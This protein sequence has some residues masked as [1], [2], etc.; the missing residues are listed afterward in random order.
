M[1][2]AVFHKP[3]DIRYENIADAEIENSTD[4]LLR[5]TSTSL[6]G[7][8]LHIYNGFFPQLRPMVLG[9]EFMGVVE[10]VGND[11][12]KF[13]KGDRVIVP[14]TIACG[15]CFFCMHQVPTG[16]SKSNPQNYG[17]EGGIV[18]SKGAGLFG[19]TDLY[20]GYNGGQAEAVRVPYADFGPRKVPDS[21]TDEQALFLT[22][23]LPTGWAG[24]DK[25]QVKAG[26]TVVVFGCGPVGLMAQKAAWYKGAKR[27]IA[28]DVLPYRLN[29]AHEICKSE[30]IDSS[31]TDAVS[32][33][34]ELTK[35][36]GADVCI[37]AV[38][39]EART[40][41]FEKAANVIN[42]QAGSSKIVEQA[43]HAT[44]RGGRISLLG[45]YATNYDNFPIGGWID[46]G[47]Q[48]WGGLA[49][50]HNYI[51]E[52][53]MMVE[54]GK[55]KTEDIITHS[56]RLADITKAYTMFNKKEDSCIKVILK[57]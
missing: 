37:D 55:L 41:I 13:K 4:L 44:R 3:H 42:L 16:C 57:P 33:I 14:F 30:T 51:D 28:V 1:K 29:M 22:D 40:N 31:K 45:I 25:S 49:P 23:I 38:G 5:V 12:K 36:Y 43:I 21:L 46:K 52:I 18:T 8:D 53:I 11:V 6:G 34:I 39:L 20:G 50:V 56:M 26:D 19:Y 54:G 2:A 10:D 7:S 32:E 9:H 15:T 24:A 17:P 35:G 47:L 48:I 27:V